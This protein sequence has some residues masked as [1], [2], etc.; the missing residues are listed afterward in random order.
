MAGKFHFAEISKGKERLFQ[1][2]SLSGRLLCGFG[3][4]GAVLLQFN[5]YADNTADDAK[6]GSYYNQTTS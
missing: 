6:E 1:H 5:E 2:D 3:H 4:G